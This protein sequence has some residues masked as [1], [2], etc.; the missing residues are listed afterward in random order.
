MESLVKSVIFEAAEVEE[1]VKQESP[2]VGFLEMVVNDD[3]LAVISFNNVTLT[4]LDGCN[5]QSRNS[6][7]YRI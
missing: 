6:L 7:P 3:V 2:L 1:S 4:W 5:L